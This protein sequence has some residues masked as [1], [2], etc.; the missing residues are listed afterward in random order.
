MELRPNETFR[1]GLIGCGAISS[2]H[3]EAL[4]HLAHARLVAVADTDEM[5][6]RQLAMKAAGESLV[7]TYSDYRAMLDRPDVDGVIIATPSGLHARMAL[8]AMDAGKHVLVEKPLALKLEDA[9]LMIR[10]SD[11]TKRT[12]AVVHHNRFNQAT[13]LL[14]KTIDSGTMGRLIWGSASVRWFRPQSYYSDSG[15]RGTVAMDG[16]VLFNQAI[17]HIDLLLWFMGDVESFA[18]FRATLGHD[19]EAEDTAVVSLRF[20]SGALGSIDATTCAFPRNLEES[21]TVIGERGSVIMGGSGFDSFR[22]WRVDGTDEPPVFCERPKWYGHYLVIKDF[23]EASLCSRQP[24][25]DGA[26]GRKAV[27]FIVKVCQATTVHKREPV[28]GKT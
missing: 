17:H 7:A 18:G 27:E 6:A 4:C 22:V 9:D 25:V 5:R 10:K 26:E 23:I 3:L 13:Q 11:E 16:G 1:L 19:M 8:D 12:L 14:K 15:W 2:K 21:I 28:G 20:Q 24:A